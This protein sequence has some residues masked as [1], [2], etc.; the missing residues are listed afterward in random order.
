MGEQGEDGLQDRGSSCNCWMPTTPFRPIL[1]KPPQSE[2]SGMASKTVEFGG[3]GSRGNHKRV[4]INFGSPDRE[5]ESGF[6]YH[7]AGVGVGSSDGTSTE[8]HFHSVEKWRGVSCKDL[9]VLAEASA[10]A[11]NDRAGM[12][13]EI[14]RKCN[15]SSFRVA[16]CTT[17]TYTT[18]TYG[19]TKPRGRP[20]NSGG[21][22]PLIIRG[23][24]GG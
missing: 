14:P 3:G 4:V 16:I 6:V 23:R 15:Q 10:A 24:S 20:H 5:E 2:V 22:D 17:F 19:K 18:F 11:G 1:P 21:A 9:L 13:G 12:L 8:A 7:G